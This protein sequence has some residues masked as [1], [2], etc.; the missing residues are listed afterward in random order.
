MVVSALGRFLYRLPSGSYEVKRTI[1]GKDFYKT[2]KSNEFDKAKKYRDNLEKRTQR[3]EKE[4][5]RL[6]GR[7]SKETKLKKYGTVAAGLEKICPAVNL[8]SDAATIP[9]S[10]L[11]RGLGPL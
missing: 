6:I 10:S 9:A 7:K 3:L 8:R 11:L 2:F 5:K 4:S 1:G